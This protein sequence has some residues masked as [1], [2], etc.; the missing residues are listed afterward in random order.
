LTGLTVFTTVHA[1][2]VSVVVG[3]F[4]HFGIDMFGFMSSLNGVVVQRLLRRLCGECA[5]WAMPSGEDVEWLERVDAGAV[6]Q[7]RRAVGCTACRATGYRGRFVVAE[8][9][10]V[11]DTLRDGVTAGVPLSTIKAHAQISGVLSLE[12]QA[13]SRVL[14]GDT[15]VAEVRRAV[16]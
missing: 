10:V 1:N 5:Q 8:I 4:R 12:Q 9:H 14:A 3:R 16:G 6:P 11:D 13:L 15:T 2:S 7:L